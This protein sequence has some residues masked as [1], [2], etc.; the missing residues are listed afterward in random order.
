MA[1]G[2]MGLH[3]YGRRLARVAQAAGRMRR[4]D[5]RRFGEMTRLIGLYQRLHDKRP[6]PEL[7]SAFD[8]EPRSDELPS[9][10][11]RITRQIDLLMRLVYRDRYCM[12]RS[13]LH[14]HYMRRMGLPVT[15]Q[16]GVTR[17]GDG[18][19]G[20]AWV[21]LAGEPYAERFDPRERFART[22]SYPQEP[23]SD[24]SATHN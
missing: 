18:L 19:T 10:L 4:I 9:D 23:E 24:S 6:L 14:F 11:K 7:V 13:L 22:W 1:A 3:G 5:L 17:T 16:F 21:E 2:A 15:L 20:H 12:K 8:S